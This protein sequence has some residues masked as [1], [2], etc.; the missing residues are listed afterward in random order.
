MNIAD[1]PGPLLG[2]S[3]LGRYLETLVSDLSRLNIGD[4][5]TYIPQLGLAD[6]TDF[7]VAIVTADG[8]QYK[9]GTCDRRV[10]IQSVSKPFMYGQA[11]DQFGR[12]VVLK[13]VGVEPTGERF[14]A[15]VLDEANNRAFNPMVNSGAIVTAALLTRDTPAQSEA[16]MLALFS[17]LAGRQL[18]IDMPVFHSEHETG[19]RNRAIAWLMVNAGIIEPEPD[20]VLDLYFKQC[21]VLVDCTDLAAMACTL[22]KRGTQPFTGEQVFTPDT[23]RDILSVMTTCG[24]YDYAG[25]WVYDVGLPA[26]SGVSGMIMAVVPGQ[27][28]LAVYSPLL[29]SVGNSVRGIEVCRRF[30]RDFGL[31]TCASALDPGGAIRRVYTARE[32]R[33]LRQRTVAERAVLDGAGALFEAVEL[34]GPLYFAAA[35]RVAHRTAEAAQRARTVVLDLTRVESIDKGALD[36]LRRV[37]SL[38]ASESCRFH[39]TGIPD[40]LKADLAEALSAW[41]GTAVLAYPTTESALEAF[42]DGVLTGSGAIG[43][44]DVMRL[45]QADIFKGLGPEDIAVLERAASTFSY[46]AGDRIIT[47]GDDAL[48]VYV[49]ARGV[50]SITIPLGSGTRRISAVGAGQA[51]G[52]M[53]MLDGGRRSANAVASGAVICHAFAIDAIRQI[54]KDHPHIYAVILSN[55]VRSL[56]DRLRAANEQLGTFG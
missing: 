34:T 54:A 10:T 32:V 8:R 39:V 5:A 27:L 53:A 35:E 14:N 6:P 41:N 12:E 31:H 44:G 9:A 2:S 11:L 42:E 3:V 51:F 55:L 45:S 40:R 18:D 21:S 23:T 13:S 30:A 49:V 17:R 4:I 19:H 48:A 46:A 50:V 20:K 47:H 25:Q 24:M 52:E 22:A 7:G 38:T 37:A 36:I 16:D 26:K 29:D 1:R 56:S 28:G 43:I 33:S 15:I